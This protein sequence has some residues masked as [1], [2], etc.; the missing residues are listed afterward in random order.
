MNICGSNSYGCPSDPQ[1]S[2]SYGSVNPPSGLSSF[3]TQSGTSTVTISATVPACGTAQTDYAPATCTLSSIRP[4]YWTPTQQTDLTADA[5][6]N[7]ATGREFQALCNDQ[8]GETFA[9]PGPVSWTASAGS[10]TSSPYHPSADYSYWLTSGTA[11]P[12]TIT[13]TSP[14]CGSATTSYERPICSSVALN[15]RLLPIPAPAPDLTQTSPIPTENLEFNLQCNDQYGERYP[16]AGAPAWTIQSGTFTTS[17]HDATADTYTQ[18]WNATSVYGPYDFTANVA[19]CGSTTWTYRPPA[20][21]AGINLSY[22]YTSTEEF[23][24]NI[25]YTSSGGQ[26][27][28]SPNGLE[29]YL[30]DLPGK[31]WGYNWTYE[32]LNRPMPDWVPYRIF[33]AACN[34]QYGQAINCPLRYWNAT[35]GYFENTTSSQIPNRFGLPANAIVWRS[36]NQTERPNITAVIPYC[37]K[38]N[39]SFDLYVHNACRVIPEPANAIDLCAQYPWIRDDPRLSTACTFPMVK[40][41]NGGASNFTA[42]CRDDAL[43]WNNCLEPN[44]AWLDSN[45]TA[46]ATSTNYWQG[47]QYYN[48][49]H[50]LVWH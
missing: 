34:D 48:E 33:G 50:D 7:P 45:A 19:G 18:G 49:T 13:A 28:W 21:C 3:W 37:G 36:G 38:N 41:P 6:T 15:P 10:F 1:W 23:A 39:L 26:F 43:Q 30:D 8:Y 16:C 14:T 27:A 17:S 42:L 32:W 46:I 2:A 12:V 24:R 20:V 9:C 40:L 35:S 31:F 5:Y 25:G 44:F 47:Y 11:N 4:V 22:G 29:N